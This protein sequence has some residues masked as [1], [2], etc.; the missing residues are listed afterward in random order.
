MRPLK[1]LVVG[2]DKH[3][4][5]KIIVLCENGNRLTTRKTLE[6][7]IGVEVEIFIEIDT[8]KVISIRKFIPDR[9]ESEE[10]GI[11][12]TLRKVKGDIDDQD[13]YDRQIRYSPTNQ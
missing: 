11:Q 2:L 3:D 9:E 12:P 4:R 5:N 6:I 13:Y 10:N 7:G 8:L 1:G